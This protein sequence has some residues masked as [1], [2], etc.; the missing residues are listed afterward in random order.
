M[1]LDEEEATE[2]EAKTWCEYY[3]WI[4]IPNN[5]P[6]Y[7]SKCLVSEIAAH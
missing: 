5:A 6:A 7:V 2:I 1:F 4:E 3:L